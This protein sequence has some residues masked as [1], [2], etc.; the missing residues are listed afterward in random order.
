[1][2]YGLKHITRLEKLWETGRAVHGM[3]PVEALGEDD[4]FGPTA[5]G[6]SNGYTG[7]LDVLHLVL[8]MKKH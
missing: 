1:M 3:A 2:A 6:I 5:G 8:R 4:H 7:L